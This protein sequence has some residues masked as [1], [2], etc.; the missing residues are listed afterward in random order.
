MSDEPKRPELGQGPLAESSAGPAKRRRGPGRPFKP[1]QSGNPGGRPSTAFIHAIMDEAV[2][3]DKS[4]TRR[5]ALVLSMFNMSMSTGHRNQFD[6]G[7]LLMAYG[8]GRPVEVRELSGPGG[9]PIETAARMTPEQMNQ[10]FASM[11]AQ[12]TV[13]ED[14]SKNEE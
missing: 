12:M 13:P 1:G 7:Q 14:G 2:G 11:L 4:M 3:K 6:A 5:R 9:G 8:F 10:E